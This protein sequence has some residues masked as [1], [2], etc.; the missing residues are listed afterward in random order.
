MTGSFRRLERGPTLAGPALVNCVSFD[1]RFVKS[2]LLLAELAFF[3]I[4]FVVRPDIAAR[5]AAGDAVGLLCRY[6]AATPAVWGVAID[7]PLIVLADVSVSHQSDVMF[8][9]G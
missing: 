7:V 1:Y 8:T 3:T 5:T 4:P 9:P 6:S 2:R